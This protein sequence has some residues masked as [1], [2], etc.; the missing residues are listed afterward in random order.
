MCSGKCAD[1]GLRSPVGVNV[2]HHAAPGIDIGCSPVARAK[3]AVMQLLWP[4]REDGVRRSSSSRGGGGCSSSREEC[5]AAFLLDPLANLRPVEV[6][7]VTLASAAR[8]VNGGDA[9]EGRLHT[10][11]AQQL[12]E[13]IEDDAVADAEEEME[14]SRY[15]TLGWNGEECLLAYGTRVLVCWSAI[16]R[17]GEK[18]LVRDDADGARVSG[19]GSH[20]AEH[21]IDE[22]PVA[23]EEGGACVYEMLQ[24]GPDVREG[25]G[26]THEW[27]QALRTAVLQLQPA[28]SS[29]VHEQACEVLRRLRRVGISRGRNGVG[30]AEHAAAAS[31][32]T[33]DCDEGG[34]RTQDRHEAVSYT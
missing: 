20:E 12:T 11:L 14:R 25:S 28:V 19:R 15:D 10:L 21:C 34:L 17:G 32:V 31:S 26:V 16:A 33:A 9:S 7:Q 23:I 24:H 8:R 30:N 27:S 22:W 13:G 5:G 29:F 2:A 1:R 4:A 3:Q 18:A 6:V